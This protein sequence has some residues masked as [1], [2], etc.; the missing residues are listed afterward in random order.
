[1]KKLTLAFAVFALALITPG[2]ALASTTAGSHHGGG[3]DGGHGMDMGGHG[4]SN[5]PTVD[6]AREIQV[7]AGRLRFSPKT[8]TV[9]A[10]ED[11]TIV[12]TSTDVFHD[13]VVKGAGHVVGAK[14]KKTAEGGLRID[15]PGTYKFW[16]SVPGHRAAGMKGTI[17]VE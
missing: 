9:G 13:L 4:G 3:D 5:A 6:A 12:M 8:I 15:T 1:M 2:I 16:C 14:R 11:V 17:T 10:G 7:K